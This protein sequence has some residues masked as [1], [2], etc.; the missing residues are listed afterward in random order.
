MINRIFRLLC[1]AVASATVML[2]VFSSCSKDEDKSGN[3][4][5]EVTGTY[6]GEM[7]QK[8]GGVDMGA[9]PIDLVVTATSENTLTLT[10][11]GDP[12]AT[13]DR[14]LKADL[15]TSGVEIRKGSTSGAYQLSETSVDCEVAGVRYVG[16]LS[17]SVEGKKIAVYYLVTPG[18]MPFPLSLGFTGEKR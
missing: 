7:S 2:T 12:N 3:L 11:K 8:A 17:G 18:K 4:A 10:L 6:S 9:A 15:V 16:T 13:L 14:A 5:K 1:I